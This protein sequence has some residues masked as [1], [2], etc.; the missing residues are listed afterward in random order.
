VKKARIIPTTQHF[1]EGYTIVTVKKK[2]SW[3]HRLGEGEGKG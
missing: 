3:L 1:G 2:N